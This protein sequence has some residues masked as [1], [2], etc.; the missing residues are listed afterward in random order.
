MVVLQNCMDSVKDEP[1]S[2]SET[3]QDENQVIGVKAEDVSDIEIEEHHEPITFPVLKDE[4]EV[5]PLKC[6]LSSY[7]SVHPHEKGTSDE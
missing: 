1:D 3:C 6:Q 2:N 4:Q 7:V 5:C